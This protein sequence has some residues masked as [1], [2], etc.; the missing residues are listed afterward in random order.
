[1]MQRIFV[2][3]L[4]VC[5]FLCLSEMSF[6]STKSGPCQVRI[7]QSSWSKRKGGYP[8]PKSGFSNRKGGYHIQTLR[9][10]KLRLGFEWRK[11]RIKKLKKTTGRSLPIVMLDAKTTRSRW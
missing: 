10:G 7:M 3:V 5:M 11:G 2:S 8:I 6:A 4:G 9:C 1:M